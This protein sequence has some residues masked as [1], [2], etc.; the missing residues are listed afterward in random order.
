[1]VRFAGF[2]RLPAGAGRGG[3]RTAPRG[4]RPGGHGGVLL[5]AVRGVSPLGGVAPVVWC[6]TGVVLGSVFSACAVPPS[7]T[8]GALRTTA[9]WH[10]QK[11]GISHLPFFDSRG[12]YSYLDISNS[13][14]F[15][16]IKKISPLIIASAQ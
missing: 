4:L 3:R 10:L 8:G 15:Y 1:M 11:Y 5:G 6:C 16:I 7:F 14:Q 13:F 12:A 9:S 2:I